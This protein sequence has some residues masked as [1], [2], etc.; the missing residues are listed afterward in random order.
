MRFLLRSLSKSSIDCPSTPAAP[1]FAF[2]CLYA[3][4]TSRLAIQN[5][6]AL[7]TLIIPLRVVGGI[8]PDD[9]VPSVQRHYSTFI[10][11]TDASAPV[12]RIG[13]LVLA[14]TD[15]LDFSLNIGT[16]GSCVP[17]RSPSQ[18][19]AAFMPDAG[20]AV[21]RLP[22]TLARGTEVQIPVSTSMEYVTTRHQRF[23]C[24]RL[25]EPH[26]TEFL[27]PFPTTLTTR[28]LYPRSLW[29]F[30]TCPCRPIPEGLPPSSIKLRQ[31][32]FR[33]QTSTAHDF[34]VFEA[35]PQS[36][37]EDV[38][39]AAALPSMLIVISWRFKVPVK[40]SLVNWLPWSV[41][42]ISGLP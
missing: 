32:S 28:A 42:K 5:G 37:D 25:L 27:P 39:H 11:I 22:P 24:V 40:S 23:T 16:T 18:G 35:P 12:F 30:G 7:S 4:H 20:W 26:L 6:L 14:V 9:D 15:R 31:T 21:G 3:S 19:H 8:K 2:T 17:Y 13:T 41:L 33:G 29:R 10:P 1:R 38:V 34:L 36:L